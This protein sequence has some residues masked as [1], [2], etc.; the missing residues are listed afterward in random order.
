MESSLSVSVSEVTRAGDDKASFFLSALSACVC[1]CVLVWVGFYTNIISYMHQ[2][3]SSWP[4][5]LKG[6]WS[7]SAVNTLASQFIK[8]E[9]FNQSGRLHVDKKKKSLLMH[10]I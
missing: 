7:S 5:I 6:V 2:V 1:M 3:F 4:H 10:S 9:W 8:A